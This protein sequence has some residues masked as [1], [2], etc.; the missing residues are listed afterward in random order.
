MTYLRALTLGV[1][2]FYLPQVT[3][4]RPI[5]KSK[6][7][8]EQISLIVKTVMTFSLLFFTVFLSVDYAFGGENYL[9]HREKFYVSLFKGYSLLPPLRTQGQQI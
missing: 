5:V 6:Y 3:F 9:I 1:L 2:G 4:Q 7:G 8:T